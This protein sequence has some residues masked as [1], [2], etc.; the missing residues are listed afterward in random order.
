[1]W[2]LCWY[3]LLLYCNQYNIQFQTDMYGGINSLV[4][5]LE[6]DFAIVVIVVISSA[7]H[8]QQSQVI[9][10]RAEYNNQCT[11]T[12]LYLYSHII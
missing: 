11:D 9:I 7:V 1:M 10:G 2:L 6:G 12:Y 8:V 4:S 5:R 3:D